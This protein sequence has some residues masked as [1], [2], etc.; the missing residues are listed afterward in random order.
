MSVRLFLFSEGMK[1]F[2]H[3]VFQNVENS[4]LVAG[5]LAGLGRL[6]VFRLLASRMPESSREK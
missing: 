5:S 3:S 6:S 4:S 2:G 1:S